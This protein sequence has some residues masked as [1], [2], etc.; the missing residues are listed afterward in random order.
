[1]KWMQ[2]RHR[3]ILIR[4][5]V[6]VAILSI[7]M[8]AAVVTSSCA[9]L[10]HPGQHIT[11]LP[12]QGLY[13]ECPVAD[14]FRCIARLRQM[15]SAGFKL[16][17][18][19]NQFDGT[20]AEEV[21]YAQ[22]AHT[23]GMSVI[24][25]MNDP[26]FWNGT[27]LRRYFSALAKTCACSDNVG[28]IRYVINLVKHLPAT[29]GYYVGD[30]VSPGDHQRMKVFAD[31]IARLDPFHRR[32]YVA[33]ADSSSLDAYLAPFSDTADVLGADYYPVGT[34]Q[35]IEAT[36]SVAAS[37]QA[38]A[39]RY[40]KQSMMVLQAFSWSQYA[41]PAWT[42]SPYPRCS[43]F[44]TRDEM[45]QMRDLALQYVHPQFILWY[46]FY[47]IFRSDNPSAHWKDLLAAAG[48]RPAPP[49]S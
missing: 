8:V 46:S 36:S 48:L 42:C 28:L 33:G 10:D 30:E 38:I 37:L 45:R 47:D 1:M 34:T 12:P 27:D 31:L 22:Q 44:P 2:R 41:H 14:G 13:E 16:V 39:N 35:P 11:L 32:L 40:N 19:Y 49:E 26:V 18:N 24:W 43:R 5:H 15:A 20:A 3:E 6:E 4:G 25:P 29:W 21:A 17:L 7:A 9:R 23:F